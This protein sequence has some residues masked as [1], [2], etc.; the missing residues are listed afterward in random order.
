MDSKCNS[1][2]EKRKNS[3]HICMNEPKAALSYFPLGAG[4]DA[5]AKFKMKSRIPQDPFLAITYN[6]HASCLHS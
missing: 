4:A 6:L 3:E 5:L 2:K 1:L